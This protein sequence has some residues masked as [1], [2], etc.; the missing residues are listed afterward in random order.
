MHEIDE[1]VAEE[2]ASGRE[3]GQ[4]GLS[5]AGLEVLRRLYWRL[6]SDL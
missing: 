3:Y 2:S 4:R 1:R 5:L 6:T